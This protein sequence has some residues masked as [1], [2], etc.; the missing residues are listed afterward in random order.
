V[1]FELRA[2]P[3]A[4]VAAAHVH[5]AQFETFEVVSGTLGAKVAG[6]MIEAQTGDVL[7][8]EPGQA[9]KWWNAGVG[10]LV[11]RCECVRR[12]GLSR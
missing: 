5:P 4:F 12:F 2:E 11:F 1:R 6:K 10:E 3:Q 7:V 9:H 8:V